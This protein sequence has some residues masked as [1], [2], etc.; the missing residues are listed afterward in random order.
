MV[1][2]RAVLRRRHADDLGEARTERAE[3][4]AADGNA[5]I[6]D[7][8]PL[9][10]KSL[11]ALD[12]SRHEV[13]VGSL[14]IRRTEFAR[15][16]RGR[17]ERDTRHGRYIE[18]LRVVAVYDVARPTQVYEVGHLLRRHSDDGM[19]PIA[20]SG[21]RR[22]VEAAPK[23]RLITTSI[24]GIAL[25]RPSVGRLHPLPLCVPGAATIASTA[26]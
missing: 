16:V 4:G 25:A 1:V 23:C 24:A 17:H 12:A 6:G 20:P 19:R 11:R 14:A 2:A 18:G 10:Q 8:R 22:P 7:R 15:E 13:G 5:G 3:R 26:N 9:T 21:S